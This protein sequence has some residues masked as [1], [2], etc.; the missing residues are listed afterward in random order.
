MPIS[1]RF[2]GLTFAS[3]AAFIE[4]CEAI[5]YRDALD[6][7]IVGEDAKFATALLNARPDKLAQLGNRRVVRYLRKAN[8]GT[9]P[10]FFA[11]LDDGTLLDI[12]T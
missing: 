4:H 9:A 6:T 5:L 11:E 1:L 2:A 12:V 8:T 3:K 7:E 10:R